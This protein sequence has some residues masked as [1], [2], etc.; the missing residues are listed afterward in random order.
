MKLFMEYGIAPRLAV[1][2]RPPISTNKVHDM[3]TI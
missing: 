3:R 2:D 1:T